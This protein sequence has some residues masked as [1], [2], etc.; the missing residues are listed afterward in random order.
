MWYSGSDSIQ[1][2]DITNEVGHRHS[3]VKYAKSPTLRC[4]LVEML[5][6]VYLASHPTIDASPEL[7]VPVVVEGEGTEDR[8]GESVLITEQLPNE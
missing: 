7:N 2:S 6:R 8:D 3:V 4:K 1:I 5:N